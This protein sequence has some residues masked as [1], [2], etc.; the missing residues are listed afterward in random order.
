MRVCPKC[1][2]R[3]PYYWRVSHQQNPTGE[4]DICTIDEFRELHPEL[5]ERIITE[6]IVIEP[7]YAYRKGPRAHYVQRVDLTLYRAGGVS[8]FKIPHETGTA[9]YRKMKR[10]REGR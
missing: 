1:G 9:L 2:Y 3:D 10:E 6:I 5:A 7:P 4:I 8:A